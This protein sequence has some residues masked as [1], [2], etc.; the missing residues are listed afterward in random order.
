LGIT[1]VG[2]PCRQTKSI[3]IPAN[4]MLQIHYRFSFLITLVM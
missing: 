1:T 4:E 3:R 2:Q